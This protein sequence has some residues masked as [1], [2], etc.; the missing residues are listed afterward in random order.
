MGAIGLPGSVDDLAVAQVLQPNALTLYNTPIPVPRTTEFVLFGRVFPEF[1]QE[2][3]IGDFRGTYSVRLNP[4]AEIDE[5]WVRE[6]AVFHGLRGGVPGTHVP[7]DPEGG[8]AAGKGSKGL[9]SVAAYHFPTG[10]GGRLC[11][12]TVEEGFPRENVIEALVSIPL[13]RCFILLNNDVS[14][15]S[16]GI[17]CG[18]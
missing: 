18:R 6:N 16:E 13:V 7:V 10:T 5:L 11:L 3:P 2:G 8:P 9:P 1:V 4:I 15:H 17:S 12:L 14:L